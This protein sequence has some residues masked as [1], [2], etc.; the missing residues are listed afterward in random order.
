ML[1]SKII[2]SFAAL[3]FIS[4]VSCAQN[5]TIFTTKDELSSAFSRALTN[6][7]GVLLLPTLRTKEVDGLNAKQIQQFLDLVMKPIIEG[8]SLYHDPIL[9]QLP[10]KDESN[11]VVISFK[12]TGG[13]NFEIVE[14]R[15]ELFKT[16]VKKEGEGFKSTVSFGQMMFFAAYQLSRNDSDSKVS[17]AK[18]A[19]DK[20]ESWIPALTKIGIK[21]TTEPEKDVYQT[22]E[23]F[24]TAS[25]K[26]IKG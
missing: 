12:P 9:G 7:D 22:W 11:P 14:Y 21:G 16:P 5:T 10:W 2:S 15:M 17:M 6:S 24:I 19:Q 18:Y 26:E 25:R 3:C 4:S 20:V 1:A 13:V 23:E 8:P